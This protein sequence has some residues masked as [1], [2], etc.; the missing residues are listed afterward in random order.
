MVIGVLQIEIVIDGSE[1]LKDKRRVVRSLKDR[2]HRWH[3]VSVAEVGKQESLTRGVLG[4][5][6]AGSDV[7][8]A[9]SV[10]DKIVDKLKQ[11]RGYYLDDYEVEI[12]TGR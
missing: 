6:L 3:Q 11:G 9:Q 7:P 5:V 1:S 12:L 10:L 2:L 4:I 8:Y